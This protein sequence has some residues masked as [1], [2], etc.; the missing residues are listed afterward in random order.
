MVAPFVD[1]K[2]YVQTIERGA[3]DFIVPPFSGPEL[4]HVLRVAT[5]NAISRRR[6]NAELPLLSTLVALSLPDH[7][8]QK[9]KTKL[10]SRPAS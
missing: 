2:F 4:I 5:E 7:V 3:F 6:K 9:R 10:K 8:N 1:V